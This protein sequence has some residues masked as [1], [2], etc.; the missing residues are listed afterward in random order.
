MPAYGFLHAALLLWKR[1]QI[2]EAKTYFSWFFSVMQT[3]FSTNLYN[4]MESNVMTSSEDWLGFFILHSD[5]DWRMKL[6]GFLPSYVSFH[7][8]PSSRY[9]HHLNFVISSSFLLYT[10]HCVAILDDSYFGLLAF[11]FFFG[12]SIIS[13]RGLAVSLN[14]Q[15]TRTP[16]RSL[17][18]LI[19]TCN[20]C[21]SNLIAGHQKVMLKG[22]RSW[23]G[24]K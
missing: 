9:H 11:I 15:C 3:S 22:R 12:T 7:F 14:S 16:F 4:A 6:K 21:T 23:I 8:H 18:P 17:L 24:N 19:P 10:N 13:R 5:W 2:Q 1:K 20:L